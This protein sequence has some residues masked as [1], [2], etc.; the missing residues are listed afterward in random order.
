MNIKISIPNQKGGVGKTTSTVNIAHW[1]AMQG[2]RVLIVDLDGQGHCGTCLGIAKGDELHRLIVDGEPL[3]QVI[4]QARENLWVIRN[5][6]NVEHVKDFLKAMNPRQ[7]VLINHLKRADRFFDL[8]FMDTPATTDVLNL[9]ALVASNF[10]FVP[11]LLDHLALDGVVELIK[12][13][14]GLDIYPGINPPVIAGILPTMFDR[15]TNETTKNFDVL[16]DI[17]K[18]GISILPPIP[19]DTKMRE[20]SA[21]GQTIWEYAPTTAAAIGINYGSSV[22]NSKGLTGGYLHICEI[23]DNFIR[24]NK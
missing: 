24:S 12:L 9:L 3:E 1:F 5:D 23:I 15:T 18:D 13:I 7:G 2:K 16:R 17:I 4:V 19:R 22:L 6:H 20:A 14:R 21:Y 11:T 10:V 8:T